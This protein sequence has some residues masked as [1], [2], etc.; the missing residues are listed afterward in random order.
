MNVLRVAVVSAPGIWRRGCTA[1]LEAE[2]DIEVIECDCPESLAG[3]DVDQVDVV[4]TGVTSTSVDDGTR[5]VR[6]LADAGHRVVA[7]VGATVSFS[8]VLAAGACRC[9]SGPALDEIDLVA[10]TRAVA[11]GERCDP[12]DFPTVPSLSPRERE[13]LEKLASGHTDKEIA[14][15]LDISVRTVQ[16]HLD[17]IRGKTERHR[18]AELT[19]LAYELGL[20]PRPEGA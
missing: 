3:R 14:S 9:I 12:G 19:A 16:S 11:G 4:V 5:V 15:I 10:C 17:R 18:R 2:P 20:G 6:A 13:V 7:V 1:A 8:A